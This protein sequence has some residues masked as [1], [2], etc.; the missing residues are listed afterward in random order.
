MEIMTSTI[1]MNQKCIDAC[2]KCAQTCN[3]C[4]VLCLNEPDV[5]ARKN[6]IETL[7]ACADIC[8]MSSCFMG[9]GSKFS[10]DLC[11]LCASE[12]RNMR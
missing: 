2:N 9:M 12:C 1:G 10:N 4:M 8:K 6:C 5:Q 7:V 3:E 11:Q